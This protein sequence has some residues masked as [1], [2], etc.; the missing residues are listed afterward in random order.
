MT[1][2]QFE[3]FVLLVATAGRVLTHRQLL[4]AIWGP[5]RVEHLQYLRVCMASLRH[6]LRGRPG[7]NLGGL[8]TETGIGYRLI[9]GRQFCLDPARA[10]SRCLPHVPSNEYVGVTS[11]PEATL[12]L[13]AGAHGAVT[14]CAGVW[15]RLVSTGTRGRAVRKNGNDVEPGR[16]HQS[17]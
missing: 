5:D 7:I 10:L 1:R 13:A 9:A 17:A 4:R 12:W 3:L 11:T 2:T 16:E 8:M 14:R 6:K 15:P